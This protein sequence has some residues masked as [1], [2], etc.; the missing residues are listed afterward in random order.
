MHLLTLITPLTL[1]LAPYTLAQMPTQFPNQMQFGFIPN[2]TAGTIREPFNFDC[3][4]GTGHIKADGDDCATFTSNGKGGLQTNGGWLTMA[5]P[6]TA[7]GQ[8][9]VPGAMQVTG[10]KAPENIWKGYTPTGTNFAGQLSLFNQTGA[11]PMYGPD[12]FSGWGG[13]GST[14]WGGAPSGAG[15]RFNF[16]FYPNFG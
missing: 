7:L 8:G 6:Q 12:W 11:T 1:A 9:F 5:Q 13:D 4:N 3:L 14:V 10:G 2:N 16:G 15:S